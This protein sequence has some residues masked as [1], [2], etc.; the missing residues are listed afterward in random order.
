VIERLPLEALAMRSGYREDPEPYHFGLL[1]ADLGWTSPSVSIGA[2]GFALARDAGTIQPLV[3][4]ARGGRVVAAAQMHFFQG[5]LGVRPRA[6]AWLFGPRE[7]EASPAHVLPGYVTATVAL[8]LTIAD[9]MV[10]IEGRNLEDQPRPQTWVDSSTGVEALGPG[11]EIR[12]TLTWRL[13][14]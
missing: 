3:D 2:E 4:P 8:E 1:V 6:E 10:T 11:R 12:T 5:D 7:S 14:D 13:W 9:A